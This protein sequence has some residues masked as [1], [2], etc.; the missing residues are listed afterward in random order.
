MSTTSRTLITKPL[1]S[2]QHRPNQRIPNADVTHPAVT[3]T[4]PTALQ[5]KCACGN[6]TLGGIRCSAC[7][8]K[9][10]TGVQTKLKVNASRG[11]FEQEADRIAD[12]VMA[13]PASA[14]MGRTAPRIQRFSG[15]PGRSAGTAPAS[16]E[17]VL[18]RSG[19]PLESTLRQN[20]EQRFGYDFSDVRTHTD[21]AARQSA[22]DV[23]A[24]A[25]T[26]GH[27][28]V[29][30]AGQFSPES[31]GGMHLLA[32]EL[33]HV[34]QQSGGVRFRMDP[35]EGKRNSYPN[36]PAITKMG[37]NDGRT[38]QLSRKA[39]P[40][41]FHPAPAPGVFPPNPPAPQQVT[42]QEGGPSQL[43][44][45]NWAGEVL[46][47]EQRQGLADFLYLDVG[48]TPA[49]TSGTVSGATFILHDTSGASSRT[50][51]EHNA[52]NAIGPMG[53][54]PNAFI[55]RAGVEI[56][57]RPDFF[58]PNRPTTTEFEKGT[59]ILDEAHRDAAL[60]E[61]WNNTNSANRTAAIARG[62]TGVGLSASQITTITA[63]V[64]NYLNGTDSGLPDGSKTAGFWTVREICSA[65]STSGA[66]AVAPAGKD[67]DL[68]TACGAVSGL[69]TARRAR[70]GSTASVELVQVGSRSR[71]QSQNTCDP[72]NPNNLPLQNPPYSDTQ[73][74]NAMLL[75]LSAAVQAGRFPE[76][77]THF[78]VDAFVGGHCDPRCFDLHRF[79]RDIATTLQPLGHGPASTYG[80]RPQYGLVSG[81]DNVWW[82]NATCHHAPPT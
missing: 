79:Y 61:V 18:S 44:T 33:T 26:V 64:Q 72:T 35:S 11:I 66:A 34:L 13:M 48:V 69:L 81:T 56:V 23:N 16:V 54:G 63:G 51:I 74:Q 20:M 45:K 67:A 28:I 40:V 9:Q 17:N 62:L 73:Y 8:E 50:T 1:I 71:A 2:K 53:S 38:R 49:D 55:P 32:H 77:K 65:V 15:S 7:G 58:D 37:M 42:P 39:E 25:Y 24:L 75:Y 3:S 59:D 22:R 80:I 76:V 6:H 70:I 57:Q 30:G 43:V 41:P 68:T 5:R 82:D 14:S 60:R 31:R 52:Q 4:V 47:D 10:Q 27:N 19:R 29:F 36:S 78:A 46:R 12:Q 21:E